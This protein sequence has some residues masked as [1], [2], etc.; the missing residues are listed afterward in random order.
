MVLG[1]VGLRV[2]AMRGGEGSHQALVEF[3]EL[4]DSVIAHQRFADEQHLRA[5]WHWRRHGRRG[6]KRNGREASGAGVNC[7]A[8]Q[9]RPVLVDELGECQHQALVVL[10]AAGRVDEDHVL[11]E[12]LQEGPTQ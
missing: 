1:Q 4:V 3:G 10:H 11:A 8:H 7:G 2:V 9:I 6:A 12:R 5:H